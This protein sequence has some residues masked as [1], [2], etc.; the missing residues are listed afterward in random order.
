MS[1]DADSAEN[2]ADDEALRLAQLAC[3]RLCHDLVGPMGGVSAGLELLAESG[4]APAS[5]AARESLELL[6]TSA[7]QAARRVAF[8]RIAFGVGGG[9]AGAVPV[10]EL[11]SVTEGFL[12]G[13]RVTLMWDTADAAAQP[14]AVGSLPGAAAKVLLSMVLLG[15]GALPRGGRL[16]IHTARLPE[17][18]GLAVTAQGQGAALNDDIRDALT[19]G[20]APDL[21]TARSVH[22]HLARRLALQAGGALEAETAGNEVR[23]AAVVSD[24]ARAARAA[25]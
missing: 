12:E 8:F 18:V 16:S 4:E 1:S 19:A 24:A 14:D 10:F 13:G 15:A 17:G 5:E 23:F 25:P 3:S 21:M 20:A 7:A 9:A 11:K 22:A 2:T 6:R